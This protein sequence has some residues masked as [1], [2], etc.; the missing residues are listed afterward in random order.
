MNWFKRTLLIGVL[1]AVGLFAC[2]PE[3]SGIGTRS[4]GSLALSN[5]DALL[6]AADTDNGILAVVDTKSQAKVAEVKVGSAPV[7][8]LVGKDDTIYVANRGDR[9]VSVISRGTWTVAKRL[10]V[11]VEPSGLALT[12][13]AK[14]LLVTSATSKTRNDVGTLSGFDTATL[15]Q[16]F[17][18]EVGEEPRAVT[19]LNGDRALVSLFKKGD[20]AEVDLKSQKVSKSGTD[21]AKLLNASRSNPSTSSSGGST[22]APHGMTD[23][24]VTPDGNRVFAPVVFARETPI[25]ARP[26]PVGYYAAGGPCNIG[27]VATAGIVTVET[28]GSP[29]PKVDDLTGCSTS[30]VTQGNQD[31]PVTTLATRSSSGTNSIQGATVGVVDATGSWIYVVNR[32]SSNVAV[33]PAYR[34]EGNDLSF[35]STGSSIRN[36]VK[37]GAGADGIALASDG[38]KAYV[39]SQFDHRI[40]VLESN[41]AGNS[42][43]LVN[44]GVVSVVAKD[45]LAPELAEGRRLFYDATDARMSSSSTQV[46]CASCHY[47]GKDDAHVWQFPDGARQ[48]PVLAGRKVLSTGPWHWS[49][50]F[51]TLEKFN[52][53]TITERMGGSGLSPAAADRLNAFVDALP[54]ADNALRTAMNNDVLTKGRAAFAKANCDS[55]HSGTNFTDNRNVQVGTLRQGRGTVNPDNGPVVDKGFNV[56]SLLGV[57]RSA[58]YLHDGSQATLEERIFANTG[59]VHGKTSAL[60]DNEK[61]EL[62]VYLKSL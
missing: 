24:I 14:T 5:D 6:Y 30:G 17:E 36:T 16:K 41:G 18:I 52:V 49:G 12:A 27:S 35:D 10:E 45:T 2:T 42:A 8:V 62:V 57:G 48:T 7:R 38:L 9:S 20:V 60:S 21:L 32:E 55:C 3:V 13:D 23:L 34:R 33:L 43:R 58:P 31:F 19:A 50:E 61:R 22:F 25:L 59:D 46:A 11:G 44:K 40:E 56:P 53:H 37:V 39:Y 28:Q 51:A 4:S 1:A 54:A 29:T 47:D 15:E 26:S